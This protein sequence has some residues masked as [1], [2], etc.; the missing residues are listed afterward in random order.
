MQLYEHTLSLSPYPKL[1]RSLFVIHFAKIA[2][3]IK[4]IKSIYSLKFR[5]KNIN[6]SVVSMANE[7]RNYSNGTSSGK[8]R[9]YQVVVAATKELGIGKMENCHGNCHLILNSSRILRWELLI[10]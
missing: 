10:L 9:S 8:T 4:T 7:V 5:S 3:A 2:S 1:Q 6:I